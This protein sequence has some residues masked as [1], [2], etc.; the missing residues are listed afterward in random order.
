MHRSLQALQYYTSHSEED[1]R[2]LHERIR[3]SLASTE[4]L[5]DT[6][7]RLTGQT[8]LV[9]FKQ[10]TV[11]AEEW[12]AFL[13]GKHHD[14]LADFYG[15]LVA[16]PILK[17][18]GPVESKEEQEEIAPSLSRTHR[19]PEAVRRKKVKTRPE[20][21]VKRKIPWGWVALL[22]LCFLL[23]AGGTYVYSNYIASP[24]S[25]KPKSTI[26][27]PVT[28]EKS[29]E[30]TEE[31]VPDIKE[32]PNVLYVKT[33]NSNI[34]SDSALT[35]LLFEADFGDGYRVLET[36]DSISKVE[37]TDE[38]TGY[39]KNTDTTKSLKGDAIADESL[40]T[41]VSD[42]LDTSFV[43]ETL[44]DLIGKTAEDLNSTYGPPERTFSDEVNTYLFYGNHFFT[45]QNN[46]VIAI[47]WAETAITNAEL[48][49]LAPLQ[50]ET[51]MTGLVT[52]NSYRL[53]RFEQTE[54]STSRVRLAEQ[55]L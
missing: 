8:P 45:L 9:P 6:M 48:A 42:N 7:I 26:E 52:S 53:Q 1:I 24:S 47:D 38:L 21:R 36:T 40:L 51:E 25:S 22:I 4:S 20:P 15:T 39:I 14:E 30:K 16:R 17:E 23:G 19:E 18:D 55:N 29:K 41:W 43:T 31:P 37:L 13:A 10:D 28:V 35:D 50:L 46:K 32:E 34:Y 54:T 3:L 49:T 44:I 2:R 12:S 27:Q 5:T 33:R 11:T